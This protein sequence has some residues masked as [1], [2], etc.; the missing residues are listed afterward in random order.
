M[1]EYELADLDRFLRAAR[2]FGGKGRGHTLTDV[3]AIALTDDLVVAFASVAYDDGTQESYQLPLARR[4]GT[5]PP[6]TG[7]WYDATHDPT[8]MAE[9]L[10]RFDTGEIGPVF[11]FH[12]MP[13]AS[14]DP[15]AKARVFS[16]EQ[17]NTT[18]MFGDQG[19]FK[20]FRKLADPSEVLENPDIEIHRALTTANCPYVAHL[21]GWLD[22]HI[23]GSTVQLGVLQEFLR[24]ARDGWPL[25]LNALRTGAD[26]ADEARALGVAVRGVHMALADCF[27]VTRLD[28]G[29]IAAAMQER[30]RVTTAA[31]PAL[32]AHSPALAE[33]FEGFGSTASVAATRVH[34]DL[35]LGQTLLTSDGWKIVDFE[36][37]PAK[38][39]AERVCPDSP[40]RDV[41]GMLRSF[42]YAA[43]SVAKESPESTDDLLEAA[44]LL[45]Q[46][47]L[48]GY[49]GGRAATPAEQNLLD[50]YEAD[51]A[52]YEVLY[53]ARNR[54][55]WIDIPLNALSRV[56]GGQR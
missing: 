17:S 31:V 1:T 3:S 51:K 34:G 30:L 46:A 12:K 27:G 11:A 6:I 54:P 43:R 13:G 33:V 48:D 55:T 8:A 41:A 2:W 15:G 20:I 16:G 50:V 23:D 18:V 7:Q 47:F 9:F 21:L 44:E 10:R 49:L 53:E 42:D 37:E 32:A 14:L 39:L 45:R 36:G 26:F 28:T 29:S 22:A 38:S 35:H 19:A 40:W 24:E 5:G 4:I 25:A 56:A 52:V